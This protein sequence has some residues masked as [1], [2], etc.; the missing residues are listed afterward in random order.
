[1]SVT[2]GKFSS[3]NTKYRKIQEITNLDI[4]L[5]WYNVHS[6]IKLDLNIWNSIKKRCFSFFSINVRKQNK[7]GKIEE[8]CYQKDIIKNIFLCLKIF[9]FSSSHEKIKFY[10]KTNQLPLKIR[11]KK[12]SIIWEVYV[13]IYQTKSSHEH[14]CIKIIGSLSRKVI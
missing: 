2:F 10:L 7:K 14:P 1:V 6:D 9:G 8:K 13:E 4:R 3:Q 11:T 12:I 5:V